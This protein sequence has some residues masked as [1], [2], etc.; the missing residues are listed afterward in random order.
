M[1][2]RAAG[3]AAG[4]SGSHM[5]ASPRPGTH[6]SPAGA[7]CCSRGGA[8]AVHTAR[9]CQAVPAALPQLASIRSSMAAL[10][11]PVRT[12]PKLRFT[13]STDFSIF[14]IWWKKA[15]EAS[16]AEGQ[17]CHG[18]GRGQCQG[19]GE[20]RCEPTTAAAIPHQCEKQQSNVR[21]HGQVAA[22]GRTVSS[23]T[24]I[25][26]SADAATASAARRAG[27]LQAGHRAPRVA[28]QCVPRAQC[29]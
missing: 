16:R 3:A 4:R 8:G 27:S 28:C 1:V 20:R 14:S 24:V 23:S 17:A 11:R 25:S 26:T 15:G 6:A 18:Q 21:K 12:V 13:L 19:C 7:G 9:L 2:A 22:A 10:A 5:H 29:A